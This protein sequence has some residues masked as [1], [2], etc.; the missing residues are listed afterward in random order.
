M[1][2]WVLSGG[3]GNGS[4]GTNNYSGNSVIIIYRNP[5]NEAKPC[6]FDFLSESEDTI[7]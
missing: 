6:E 4:L 1:L 2:E 3:G 5:F 7:T